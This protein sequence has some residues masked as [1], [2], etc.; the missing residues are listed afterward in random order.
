MLLTHWALITVGLTLVAALLIL[1]SQVFKLIFSYSV[2]E[3]EIVVL[4]LHAVPI[5]RIPFYVIETLHEAPAYE[6]ALIPGVHLFTRPFARRVVIE[7][8]DRWAKYA[9]LTPNNPTEFIAD[10][11]TR[12]AA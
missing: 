1:S 3:T 11:K 8:R 9:F 4:L 6:V 12:I 5:Y 10:I 7:M 2:R